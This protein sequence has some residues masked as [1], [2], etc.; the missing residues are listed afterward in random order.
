MI[1]Y[2]TLFETIKF[3]SLIYVSPTKL[4]IK[5]KTRCI[6]KRNR[7]R[8]FWFLFS[9]SKRIKKQWQRVS[10]FNTRD[11]NSN[12]EEQKTM[13]H[14]THF[15]ETNLSLKRENI[16]FEH[17]RSKGETSETGQISIYKTTISMYEKEGTR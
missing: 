9:H 17:S 3:V 5:E 8:F 1:Q 11:T 12:F 16:L 10:S 4:N 7:N 14:Q 2:V 6:K 13:Q 15:N